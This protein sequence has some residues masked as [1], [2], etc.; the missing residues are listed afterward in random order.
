M[1]RLPDAFPQYRVHHL[2]RTAG[3]EAARGPP[4][5]PGRRRRGLPRRRHPGLHRQR[6]GR[7]TRRSCERAAAPGPRRRPLGRGRRP[8]RPLAPALGLVAPRARRGRAA[9]L[10]PGRAAR[11]GP[12]CWSGWLAGLGCY[13]IGLAWARAFN[14]YGA[15][16]LVLVEALFFAAAAAA[17]AARAGSCPGLRRRLHPGRGGPHDVALRRAPARRRLPGPGATARWS[18]LARLGGPLLSRPASGPAGWPSPR[19]SRGCAARRRG[20]EVPRW[21]GVAA[22]RRRDRRPRRRGRRGPRRRAPGRRPPGGP[23]PRG[24]PAGVEQG[25]GL[26]RRRLRRAAGGDA[27]PS[28]PRVRPRRSCSGP[29]TSSPSTG[30]WPARPRRRRSAPWPAGS[31]PPWSPGSPSR[32]RPPRSATRSWPGARA[33]ASSASSRRCTGCPSASTCPIR[34]LL[35]PLRRPVGRADRRR[36]RPRHRAHAHAGRPARAPGLLRDLLRRSQPRVG[37]RRRRAAGRPHQHLLLQHVPGARHRRSRRRAVQAV[38][39][40]RDLVQAAPTGFSAVVTQRGV[41]VERSALGRR[42]VLCRHRG[43]PPRPHPLRPLGRPPGARPLGPR[44]RAGWA[45]R[46]RIRQLP[47]YS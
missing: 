22:R 30:R 25:A 8:P 37:P 26:A 20:G 23:G 5:R 7:R 45:R 14:W 44:P 38:E 18:Q 19:W 40:G 34:S 21:S 9:L 47:D 16:V 3:V 35:R 36:P 17:H 1:T 12:G 29:R 41:V 4:R 31:T 27:T 6:P 43:A 39:T 33:A 46:W 24:R 10:A 13:A 42:Q 28:P 15:V 11:C 32:R 2:L